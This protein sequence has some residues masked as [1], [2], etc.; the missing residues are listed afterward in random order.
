MHGSIRGLNN[1]H[2]RTLYNRPLLLWAYPAT[3]GADA[4]AR[5]HAL[6]PGVCLIKGKVKSLTTPTLM[7][8]LLKELM[9]IVVM[10]AAAATA[11]IVKDLFSSIVLAL[12]FV[13]G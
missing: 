5:T 4:H 10:T 3:S 1:A 13:V 6:A 11:L 9:G 2:V 12:E 8:I 7:E